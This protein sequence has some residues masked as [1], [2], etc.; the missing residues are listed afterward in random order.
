MAVFTKLA[1]SP[2]DQVSL[3]KQRGLI[4]LDEEQALSV[5]KAVSFFRLTPYMR[6]YF[7]SFFKY[8]VIFK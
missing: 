4:L 1:I 7:P 8:M 5:L 3:L 6:H 2:I